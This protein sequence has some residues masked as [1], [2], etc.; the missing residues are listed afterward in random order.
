MHKYGNFRQRT[1]IKSVAFRDVYIYS[2]ARIYIL[3]SLLARRDENL[4]ISICYVPL[5]YLSGCLVVV[6]IEMALFV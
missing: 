1:F 2:Y 5:L 3:A 4:R 6:I